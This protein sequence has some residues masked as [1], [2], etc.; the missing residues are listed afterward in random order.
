MDPTEIVV[1]MWT[2]FIWFMT[3]SS[4]DSCEHGNKTLCSIKYGEFPAE[5]LFASQEVLCS[6]KLIKYRQK[7]L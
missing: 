6:R 2:G 1:L 5:R 3:G 4:I 7:Y